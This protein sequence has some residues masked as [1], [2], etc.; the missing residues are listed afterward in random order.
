MILASAFKAAGAPAD[1]NYNSDEYRAKLRDAI[2]STKDFKGVTGEISIDKDRNAQKPAVVLQVKG[3]SFK[4]VTTIK[5]GD[6][7]A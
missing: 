1:G 5:P 6:I 7:P 3:N 4:F 2:A